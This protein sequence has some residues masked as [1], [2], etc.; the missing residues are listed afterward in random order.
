MREMTMAEP[1][2]DQENGNSKI[3]VPNK[4]YLTTAKELLQTMPT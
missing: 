2:E 4:S 3:P 1:C